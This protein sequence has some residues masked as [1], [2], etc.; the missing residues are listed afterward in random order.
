M[1]LLY[2][3]FNPTTGKSIVGLSNKNGIY[4]GIARL[5]PE[6]KKNASEY[7][8]CRIAEGRAWI[9]YFKYEK[10]QCQEKI[11]MIKNLYKDIYRNCSENTKT[12]VSKRFAIQ[13]KYYKSK[14]SEC[15]ISIEDIENQL[16]ES[17]KIRDNIIAKSQG[18]KNEIKR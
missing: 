2:S 15:K 14:I 11:K 12:E 10:K 18:K 3:Y 13:I 4:E 8:G 7:A 6:D 1:K 5:H 9:K 17:I 16:K